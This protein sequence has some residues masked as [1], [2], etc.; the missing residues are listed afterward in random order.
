MSDFDHH[1]NWGVYSEADTAIYGVTPNTREKAEYECRLL[2]EQGETTA[3][4]A[5][6]R[7]CNWATG[8]IY[9]TLGDSVTT[10]QSD[11][12]D[13]LVL[14]DISDH[15]RPLSPHEVVRQEVLPAIE[16]LKRERHDLQRRLEEA[17]KAIRVFGG[18]GTVALTLV[19]DTPDRR[20]P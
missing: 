14:L 16:E 6:M 10:Q 12:R 8:A 7:K 15:A 19:E 1:T 11:L 3:K 20:E 13:I 5:E 4:V 17:N 18:F 2:H 9:H